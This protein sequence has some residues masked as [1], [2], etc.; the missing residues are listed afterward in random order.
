MHVSLRHSL[1]RGR[2]FVVQL[3][4]GTTYFRCQE[5]NKGKSDR[6]LAANKV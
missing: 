2:F 1:K 4:R 3:N 5:E 6:Q